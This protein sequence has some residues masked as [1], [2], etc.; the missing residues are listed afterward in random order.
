MTELSFLSELLSAIL[1]VQQGAAKLC[2]SDNM[3]AT[4]LTCESRGNNYRPYITNNL[5]LR[6]L[7]TFKGIC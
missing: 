4:H 7:Y 6:A 3:S 2:R 5:I 1:V